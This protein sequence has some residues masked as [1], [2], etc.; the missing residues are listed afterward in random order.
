LIRLGLRT[1]MDF[2]LERNTRLMS[3]LPAHGDEKV[4]V[5]IKDRL[6]FSI[7]VGLLV[8][9]LMVLILFMSSVLNGCGEYGS[10]YGS[11]AYDGTSRSSGRSCASIC[12]GH[13]NTCWSW[14]SDILKCETRCE[15]L[16]RQR[17][18]DYISV[19]SQ[20]CDEAFQSTCS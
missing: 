2:W 12:D 19:Y 9:V 14:Y 17:G 20:Q 15:T 7:M 5:K 6:A 10:Y 13:C 16:C 11:D 4:L 1:V 3:R 18:C 8:L